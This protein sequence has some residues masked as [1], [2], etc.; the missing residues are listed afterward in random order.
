MSFSFAMEMVNYDQG[1]RPATPPS[2]SPAPAPTTLSVSGFTGVIPVTW[3]TV[4]TQLGLKAP[5]QSVA[6]LCPPGN[7]AP[8]QGTY[9]YTG[10][11][12]VCTAAAHMGYL[13]PARGGIA[14]VE[15]REPPNSFPGTQKNGIQTGG[16]S[17]LSGTA[18]TITGGA[19]PPPAGGTVATTTGTPAP[20]PP[21]P[22]TR[23]PV[24]TTTATPPG[25]TATTPPPTGGDN[26]P[27]TPR[28]WRL[29]SMDLTG[30]MRKPPAGPGEGDMTFENVHYDATGGD[31]IARIVM[32][33]TIC[34]TGGGNQVEAIQVRWKFDSDIRVLRP[35]GVIPF[36]MWV[37]KVATS[38]RCPMA[39]LGR[40][41]F[42]PV[43]SY[44]GNMSP[45]ADATSYWWYFSSAKGAPGSRFNYYLSDDP[46][47]ISGSAQLV[48]AEFTPGATD[49]KKGWFGMIVSTS[50]CCGIRGRHGIFY[51]YEYVP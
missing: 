4:G 20:N 13:T 18:F 34:P 33:Q 11:S 24:T 40:T 12:S 49:A 5:G 46:S 9:V 38:S 47:T 19:L 7:P 10:E 22:A 35:G 15:W 1:G 31:F 26:L 51:T 37:S 2:G 44:G 28:T 21:P 29:I 42:V 3:Q 43:W 23:P 39:G 36:H 50:G 8:A 17:G 16:G 45:F 30:D 41:E 25:G 27:R 32:P 6:V 14:V 48:L